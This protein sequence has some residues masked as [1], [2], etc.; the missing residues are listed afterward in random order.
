MKNNKKAIMIV[1]IIIGVLV[2]TIGLTYSIF[3]IS[4]NGSNSKLVVGDV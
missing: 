4:K 1:S 3:K 2:L